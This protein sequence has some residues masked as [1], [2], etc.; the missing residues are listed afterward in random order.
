MSGPGRPAPH[1]KGRRPWLAGLI[2]NPVQADRKCHTGGRTLPAGV[3]Q[4]VPSGVRRGIG[5]AWRAARTAT[6]GLRVMPDFIIPGAQRSGTTFLFSQ[7]VRHPEIADTWQKDT[8][9]FTL[10]YGKG[11]RWYR[12][13]FPLRA[14]NAV[15]TAKGRRPRISGEATG[16]YLFHPGAPKRVHDALPD[17]K[18]VV[19]LRNPVTRAISHYHHEARGGQEHLPMADAF[20]AER[21]RLEGEL[22]KV[23]ADP[24]YYSHSHHR[25]TYLMRGLYLDQIRAWRAYYP[26]EQMLVLK[27]EDIFTDPDRVFPRIFAFLGVTPTW[28]PPEFEPRNVGKY[29]PSDEAVVERLGA[30]FKPH[31]ERL[32]EYL[33]VRWDWDD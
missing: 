27:S 28:T 15:M 3:R 24:A 16:Y 10:N 32:Y 8:E 14:G 5:R 33:D 21:E 30:Y 12:G 9:F 20:D 31:N 1:P 23:N 7:L 4:V 26:P 13:N 6:G 2:A 29:A 25:H 19:V 17:V 22:E 18:L 11:F